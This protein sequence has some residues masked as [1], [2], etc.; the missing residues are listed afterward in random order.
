[1]LSVVVPVFNSAASLPELVERLAPVLRACSSR[2]EIVL[3]DDGS[4]DDSWRTVVGLA[5]VEPMVRGVALSR[6][7]GQHN[8]LLAGLRE[9]RGEV[10]VTM[11]DDLQHRPEEI[12]KLLAA[13]TPGVDVV[14]GQAREEEHGGLRSLGSQLFKFS[15]ALTVGWKWASKVSAFR[16]LRSWVVDA[17]D[18]THDPFVNV[19]VVL[20]WATDRVTAQQVEMDRRPHGQ[21]NYSFRML[22]RHAINMVTGFSAVPLRLVAWLGLGM[23]VFGAVVIG[24]VLGRLLV[25]GHSVPGFPFLASTIALFSGA[26]LIS[27]GVI[28]DYLGRMHFRSMGRPPYWIRESTVTPPQE[29]RASTDVS[30]V[31]A[32]DGLREEALG[33]EVHGVEDE[34]QSEPEAD[35]GALRD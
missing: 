3:V 15:M 30:G 13:L 26:M 18:R 11:D 17:F 10:I 14:Y 21:S 20:S 12:P 25:T 27:L 31:V 28:G 6:N 19:D 33:G 1:M 32:P 35:L 5:A 4:I 22:V 9:A 2:A 34:V 16:V 23:A 29:V 7:Y 8:A 24:W